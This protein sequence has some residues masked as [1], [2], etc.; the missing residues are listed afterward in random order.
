MKFSYGLTWSADWGQRSPVCTATADAGP[1]DRRHLKHAG[2]RR[3]AWLGLLYPGYYCGPLLCLWP[4]IPSPPHA[5]TQRV[6]RTPLWTLVGQPQ[7]G[8]EMYFLSVHNPSGRWVPRCVLTAI[9]LCEGSPKGLGPALLP[10][11]V[12][13]SLLARAL[14]LG[15]G[16]RAIPQMWSKILQVAGSLKPAPFQRPH[17]LKVRGSSLGGC[18]LAQGAGSGA[19]SLGHHPTACAI[20]LPQGSG[21]GPGSLK[22]I[23]SACALPQGAG[24]LEVQ[25]LRAPGQALA[26][27]AT[28]PELAR[29]LRA[30]VPS[31]HSPSAWA[32]PQDAGSGDGDLDHRPSCPSAC[33]LPQDAG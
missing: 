9:P 7:L 15:T 29:S 25:S 1:V 14:P 20:P 24:S 3:P 2:A 26:P 12:D 16:A 5:V 28:V 27:L 18:A 30:A 31:R 21:W 10:R 13:D 4:S 23:P 19:G 32:L 8:V 33:R 17:C 22:Q 6:E 11:G